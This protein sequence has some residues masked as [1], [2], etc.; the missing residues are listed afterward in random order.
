[1]WIKELGVEK[2]AIISNLDNQA[3]EATACFTS[4]ETALAVMRPA[5]NSL[6]FMPYLIE[7][8]TIDEEISNKDRE[9]ILAFLREQ[10]ITKVIWLRPYSD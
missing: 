10:G 1:M 7:F 6:S 2:T 4:S 5:I 8:T 9:E 3:I